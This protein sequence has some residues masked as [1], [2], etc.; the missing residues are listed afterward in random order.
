MRLNTLGN[1]L[2]GSTASHIFIDGVQPVGLTGFTPSTKFTWIDDTH[3]GGIINL[4]AGDK[5]YSVLTSTGVATVIDSFGG[6]SVCGGGGVLACFQTAGG[7]QGVRTNVTGFGP[8]PLGAI[9][10]TDETGLSV[11]VQNYQNDFGMTTFAATG[12]SF[13]NIAVKLTPGYI[14]RARNGKWGYQASGAHI[15]NLT[16]GVLEAYAPQTTVPFEIIP[17]TISGQSWVVEWTNANLVLRPATSSSGFI[18]AS[19]GSALFNPD[20]MEISAGVVRIGWCVNTAESQTSLRLADVTV[21][22]GA[23]D[24]GTTAGGGAPVFTPGTPLTP[25]AIPVG[26][27]EGGSLT[28]LKQPRQAIK[29]EA[30]VEG[31]V[32]K[33]IYQRYWDNIVE[34]VTAGMNLQGA[35]ISGVLAADNGGTGSTTGLSVLDGAAV[36]PD[37]TQLDTAQTFGPLVLADGRSQVVGGPIAVTTYIDL[38]GSANLVVV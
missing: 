21:A 26:P 29:E 28:A 38:Q 16:T 5:L 35:G 34:A 13:Q 9:G 2:Y 30:F 19:P 4:G 27:V 25:G 14:L 31:G 11:F 24:N 15:R 36:L 7:A 32:G 22:T 18:I 37:T 8:F 1:A 6:N 20:A 33:R 10:D 17:V 12:T 23:V 3:I